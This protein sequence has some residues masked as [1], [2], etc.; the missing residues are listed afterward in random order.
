[1]MPSLSMQGFLHEEGSFGVFLLVTIILG[2]G[3]AVLAGR[4]IAQTWRPWWQIVAYMLILGAA[5]RFIHFA[6]FGG[7]LLSLHYYVVDSAICMAFG[8]IGFQAARAGQMVSQY[9]WINQPNGWLRWRRKS[10]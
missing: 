10:P 5:V 6:L 3:A 7:T 2:G 9:R 8:L 4:A 1:M